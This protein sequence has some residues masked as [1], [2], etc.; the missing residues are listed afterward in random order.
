MQAIAQRQRS[1][2]VRQNVWRPESN[3]VVIGFIRCRDLHQFNLALAPVAA[4]LDPGAWA[5]IVAI[6]QI[7]V[8]LEVTAAL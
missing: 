2:G 3:D 5:Q 4:W 7:F 1:F 8:I 6:V